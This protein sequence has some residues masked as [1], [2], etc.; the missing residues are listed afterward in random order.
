M[1]RIEDVLKFLPIPL[2][3]IIPENKDAL[4]ASNV[5]SPVTLS[6]KPQHRRPCLD[7]RR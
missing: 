1:L 7:R 2:L 5:A 6:S 4:R 3:G